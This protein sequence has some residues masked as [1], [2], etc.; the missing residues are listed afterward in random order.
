MKKSLH[1][2]LRIG[3]LATCLA[4]YVLAACPLLTSCEE[5]LT[6]DN[7]YANWKA[8]NSEAFHLRLAE[9][10]Q[11]I[12]QAQAR[13]GD[14][15]EQHCKWRLFRTYCIADDSPATAADTICVEV[16]TAGQ[17][18]GTPLY[19]DSVRVNYIGRLISTDLE[20][21]L[22]SL[23]EVF[24]H[25]GYS[26]DPADVFNPS[27]AV[28]A[29]FLVSNTVEGFTTAL[30]HMHI[31]DLWRVYIPQELGYGSAA[32]ALL[33]AYSMLIFDVQLRSFYRAGVVPPD[34]K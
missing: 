12:E 10:K 34:W 8:R 11:A 15:W 2:A 22:G 4:L 23:G 17:G 24:D 25:S 32:S 14:N 7:R 3:R 20:Q 21:P 26:K 19:T 18:S 9:A 1:L 30:Q 13:H 33:P 16:L 5:N 6:E 27:F 28:P 29:T 31:G